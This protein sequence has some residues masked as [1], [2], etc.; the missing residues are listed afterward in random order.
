M[1]IRK[2]I[3]S[4]LL[5]RSIIIV[6][7]PT[8]TVVLITALV[9]YETS[10]NII[11]KRLTQSVAADIKVV[12]KLIDYGLKFK[13]FR[14]AN[15]DFKMKVALEENKDLN[16]LSFRSSRGI[17]SRRLQ[18]ALED[19][20]KPFFYDLSNIDKGVKI[21]IQLN[22]DLLIINVH[23][24][25]LYSGSA[26]VFLLWMLFASIILLLLAYLFMKG[27]I[28]PLKR[29]AIIAETFGRGLDA[30]ELRE[31]GAS[32]IRQTTNAFN[33]MRARIKRFL[34]QRTDMLAGVSHDLRTP[35]TRMK[36]QLSLIKDLKAKKELEY[37]I[38]EMTAMLNSYVSF[39]K[40][41]A[42]DPIDAI[43][44]HDLLRDICENTKVNNQKINLEIN[45]EI[46][47]S[48]RPL[49]LK[50]C[51]INLIENAVRYSEKI[52]VELNLEGKNIIVNISDSGPGIP[53]NKYDDVFKPFFTLDPSRNKLKGESGLGLTIAKDI[54]R[55]HGGDIS[56]S[57]SSL[58]GLKVTV[59]LPV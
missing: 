54:V 42:P 10:W 22:R 17:L 57:K 36:L 5:G 44:F 26:F 41:E 15:D 30:P 39:V 34:K 46:K 31:S 16:P 58:G 38:N 3:P 51:F 27:Q 20:N 4:S 43:N 21:A 19:L 33:Q 24:D 14:I 59:A 55:S 53:Q 47:T 9:F 50:R 23:K 45:K 7:I 40:G 52:I 18:Q 32:E 1:K 29:L 13:A 28:Q 56:L 8:I 37:D 11:S 48:G 12:I 6:F 35:L 25:R 2:L 49:Q